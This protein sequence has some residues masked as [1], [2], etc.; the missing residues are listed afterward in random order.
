[1][2]PRA[3]WKGYLKIAELTCPVALYSAASTSERISFHTINRDTGNR[4]KRQYVDEETGKP[5][6]SDDQV[7][8]YET[9]KDQ[10][11]IL[12]PEEIAEAVPESDKTLSVEAFIGCSDV[13]TLYFDKPYYVAPAD[14][15]AEKAFVVIRDGMRAKNAAALASSVLFRRVRTVMLRA[16]GPGLIAHTLHFDYEIRDPAEVFD[17]IPDVRI[18]GEMLDLAKYIIETKKGEFDPSKF[19]DRYDAALAELVKA[20]MEGRKIRPPK[21]RAETKVVDLLDALRRSA[22]TEGKGA[23]GAPARRT[24]GARRKAAEGKSQP[25]RKAG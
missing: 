14:D 21:R 15:A 6:P 4:V 12:E 16:H 13:D 7:K 2:A 22:A 8:G 18:T 10:Y 1:M 25:R 23:G 5:V 24:S 9:A 11:V 20:K 3:I 17:E 19:D